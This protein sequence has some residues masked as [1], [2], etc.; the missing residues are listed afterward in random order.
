ML[1]EDAGEHWMLTKFC[2]THTYDW[3]DNRKN[4]WKWFQ[5]LVFKYFLV[6]A[7]AW[8][9]YVDYDTLNAKG[10]ISGGFKDTELC[11]SC[12]HGIS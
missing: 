8:F 6:G 11:Y 12:R 1:L 10:K 5:F 2:Q 3:H 9:Y 4:G 7:Q